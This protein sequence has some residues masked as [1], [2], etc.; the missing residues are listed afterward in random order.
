MR[1]LKVIVEYFLPFRG[2]V[3]IDLSKVH[4]ATV[5]GR[6]G[7]GKSSFFIDAILFALFG[8]ARKRPE[9]LINDLS[10]KMEVDFYFQHR[11]QYYLVER[12]IEHNKQQKLKFFLIGA[13]GRE[14]LSER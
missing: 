2:K 6:N 14:D 8:Q 3:E 9:G 12:S 4:A 13:N 10:T 11:E 5:T 1:P 7:A